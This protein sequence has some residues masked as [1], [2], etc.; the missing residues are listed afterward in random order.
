M[1]HQPTNPQDV[2]SQIR[3]QKSTT[4]FTNDAKFSTGNILATPAA[5]ELLEKHGV[6]AAL[7]LSRH[8]VGDWGDCYS[9][10]AKLNETALI[11]GSR[12][13][14]VY[15][16]VCEEALTQVPRSKRSNLPTVWVITN[17]ANANGVRDV[18]TL[19]LPEDY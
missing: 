15:R 11:D 18:T 6:S 17:A 9:D 2:L 14:S 16:L 13:F 12:L 3:A 10:D 7:L 8:I 19:L 1:N 5:I 4:I